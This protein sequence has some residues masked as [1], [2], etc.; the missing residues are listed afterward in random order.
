MKLVRGQTLEAFSGDLP[1]I[2]RVFQR[3]C[4]PVAFAHSRGAVHHDLKPKNIMIGQFGEVL[5]LDWGM[6]GLSTRHY[7]PPEGSIDAQGDVYAL[8]RILEFLLA[9]EARTPAAL[10]SIC[11]KATAADPS[12]RYQDAAHLAR[13]V[14][15]YVDGL[16]VEA[17]RQRP[18]ERGL[19]ILSRYRIWVALVLTY[20]L[21]RVVL[22][23]WPH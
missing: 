20:L 9:K 16:V 7:S 8:G 12:H 1:Q 22:V 11:A 6:P 14:A 23:F 10:Q 18:W 17:H 13:D 21:V 4:E 2:L 5:V 15:S 19:R 3:V